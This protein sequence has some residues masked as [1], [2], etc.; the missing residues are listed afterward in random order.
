MSG[1]SLSRDQNPENGPGEKLAR[2][3]EKIPLSHSEEFDLHK[4]VEEPLTT[5]NL[6][7]L[8]TPSGSSEEDALEMRKLWQ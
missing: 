1:V 6:C 8:K 3:G 7:F 4:G 5:S 2:P